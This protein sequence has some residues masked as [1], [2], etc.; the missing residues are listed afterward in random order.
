MY[1][2]VVHAHTYLHGGL[3]KGGFFCE[4]NDSF[5]VDWVLFDNSAKI[6]LTSQK[7][8]GILTYLKKKKA[9][10]VAYQLNNRIIHSFA[11]ALR[12]WALIL[13]LEPIT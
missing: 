6:G 12:L 13:M 7:P 8:T 2:S 1:L 3:K 11:M 5:A 4:N 9:A 10:R